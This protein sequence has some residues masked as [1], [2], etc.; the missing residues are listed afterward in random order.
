MCFPFP[1]SKCANTPDVFAR[2]VN[3]GKVIDHFECLSITDSRN[4]FLV[5]ALAIDENLV[6]RE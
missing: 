6:E 1:S 4:G 2:W 3:L 5:T